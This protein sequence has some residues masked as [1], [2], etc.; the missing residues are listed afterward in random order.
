MAGQNSLEILISVIG[1]AKA[2]LDEIK[3]GMQALKD[4]FLSITSAAEG[5]GEAFDRQ[6]A[7]AHTAGDALKQHAANTKESGDALEEHGNKAEGA[8][9]KHE[10]LH[11]GLVHL[12]TRFGELAETVTG[13]VEAFAAYEAIKIFREMSE[14]AAKTE[15]LEAGLHAVGQQAGYSAEQIEDAQKALGKLGLTAPQAAEGLS[16]LLGGG[17]SLDKAKELA[18]SARILAN[19]GKGSVDQILKT[20]THAVQRGRP[21][22]L[23]GIYGLAIDAKKTFLDAEKSNGAPLN[24]QQQVDTAVDS[25]VG[26]IK[27]AFGNVPEGANTKISDVKKDIADLEDEIGKNLLPT[28]LS[29]LKGIESVVQGVSKFIEELGKGGQAAD[30]FGAALGFLG[31]VAAV[32]LLPKLVAILDVVKALFIAMGPLEIIFVVASALAGLALASQDMRDQFGPLGGLVDS[33]RD[34]FKSLGEWI[35]TH[36]D[37]VKAFAG[38]IAGIAF[39]SLIPEMIAFITQAGLMVSVFFTLE[40][41]MAAVTTGARLLWTAIGGPIGIGVALIGAAIASERVRNGLAALVGVVIYAGQELLGFG[42]DVT[43]GIITPIRDLMD[44]LGLPVDGVDKFISGLHEKIKSLSKDI[45]ETKGNIVAL[46]TAAI[47]GTTND[48]PKA[49]DDKDAE[50]KKKAEAK[51]IADNKIL[52]DKQAEIN[53]NRRIGLAKVRAEG[54]V[55]SA[56]FEQEVAKNN[57]SEIEAILKDQ[58]DHGKITTEQYYSERKKAITE[59]LDYELAVLQAQKAKLD[60]EEKVA[61][62]KAAENNRPR[63]TGGPTGPTSDVVAAQY[64]AKQDK[65]DEQILL[66]RQKSGNQLENLDLEQNNKEE[67][68]ID[69]STKQ[70]E[71]LLKLRGDTLSAAQIEANKKFEDATKAAGKLSDPN[72]RSAALAIAAE[73]QQLELNKAALDESTKSRKE[74]VDIQ[75][76]QLD[77]EDAEIALAKKQGTINDF[78]EQEQKNALIQKRITLLNEQIAAEQAELA[79]ATGPEKAKIQADIAGQQGEI[80]K[81]QAQIAESTDAARQSVTDHLGTALDQVVTKTKSV[82]QAFHEMAL[83]IIDDI[84]KVATKNLAESIIGGADGKGG[85]SGLVGLGAKLFGAGGGDSAGGAGGAAVGIADIAKEREKPGGTP[86]NPLYTAQGISPGTALTT[87]GSS[88][89]NPLYVLDIG[90]SAGVGAA[91]GIGDLLGGADGASGLDALA[92]SAADLSVASG[93]SLADAAASLAPLAFAEGGHVQHFDR[94]GGVRGAGG[95]TDDMVPA[96]LSAGEHVTK[97]TSASKYKALLNAINDD[98]AGAIHANMPSRAVPRFAGG[99][100]VGGVNASTTPMQSHTRI[101]NTV[102]PEMAK[103]YMESASGERVV[104]NHIRRNPQQIQQLVR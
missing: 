22:F 27:T 99:G 52:A 14:D 56:K 47:E 45:E 25:V 80:V 65:L 83:G 92:P 76:K 63:L 19:A 64:R 7:Q 60:S 38:A 39:A 32:A 95:P 96:M 87:P 12:V 57:A 48:K 62:K 8:H 3:K 70:R 35:S 79:L 89:A 77:L 74:Y 71:A 23:Q 97:A 82:K 94:G 49:G 29:F 66:A 36:I 51:R 84:A 18:E 1:D 69:A 9:G 34:S 16:K 91:G 101:I 100:E 98:N 42:L 33:L 50:E 61:V 90:K 31:A 6:G 104:L 10:E 78:E 15:A 40:G 37:D 102:D 86:A 88:P 67:K 44:I 54:L 103:D 55:D 72:D 41:A 2:Q 13:A 24:A 30:I 17:I 43:D 46:A 53:E 11:G 93:P 59:G 28:F 20:L 4:S 5:A 85:G 21:E 58:Y 73:T 68:L 81:L 75:T 26:P